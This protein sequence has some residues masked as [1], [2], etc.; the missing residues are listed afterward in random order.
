MSDVSAYRPQSVT[1]IEN[2]AAPVNRDGGE[3]GEKKKGGFSFGDFIDTI[4]PLHHIPIVGQIYRAVT[5]DK[6]SD[7][8]RL[9][10]G[11]LFA[12]PVG[13]GIASASIAMRKDKGGDD[14][15][16]IAQQDGQLAA[17]AIQAQQPHGA[18][19]HS[20]DSRLKHYDAIAQQYWTQDNLRALSA[21][22]SLEAPKGAQKD[23]EEQLPAQPVAQVS[24]GTAL[25]PPAASTAKSAIAAQM[26]GNLE[27]LEAYRQP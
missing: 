19:P 5:G 23:G 3:D 20:L 27:K 12:G 21:S 24:A 15:P 11:G 14:M 10:G 26:L 16:Q 13:I 25:A 17:S 6:I 9:A 8:A 1:I 7:S 2:G 4:N 22:L 18:E